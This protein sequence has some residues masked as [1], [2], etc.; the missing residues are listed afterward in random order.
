RAFGTNGLYASICDADWA[1]TLKDIGGVV[2]NLICKFPLTTLK[3]NPNVL[4]DAARDIVVKVS[5]TEVPGAGWNYNCPETGFES[6]SISFESASCPGPGANI[7]FFYE[8]ASTDSPPQTCGAR[9]G[10]PCSTGQTCGNCGY[11]QGQ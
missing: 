5:G 1:Q 4:P 2:A 6:G 8:P 9:G 7:E 3:V 11:C 10:G